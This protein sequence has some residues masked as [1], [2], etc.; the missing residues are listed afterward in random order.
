MKKI[1]AV[2]LTVLIGGTTF[3]QSG[4]APRTKALKSD[5][6]S[7]RTTTSVAPF[8]TKAPNDT[9]WTEDFSSGTGWTAT[10]QGAH[11][12]GDWQ[13]VSALTPSLVAQVPPY[14]FATAMNSA[15][16][17]NFLLVDS[18]AEGGAGTQDALITNDTPID[19]SSMGTTSLSLRFTEIYRHFY[20]EN[21]IEISND[22]GVSWTSFQVNPVSQVPVNTDSGDPEYDEVN[23]T[24]A[25]GTGTW[26]TQ[27]LI[28]FR[29]V[30]QWDWFWAVDDLAI[31]ETPANNLVMVDGHWTFGTAPVIPYSKIPSSQAADITF[32]GIVKNNGGADQPNTVVTATVT[33]PATTNYVSAGQT[34]NIGVTDTIAVGPMTAA[35]QV[36]GSY[37]V[38]WSVNSDSTDISPT[39]NFTTKWPFEMTSLVYARDNGTYEGSF[40]QAD[41]DGD[42]IFD[43]SEM[44]IDYHINNTMNVESIDV[45]FSDRTPVGQEL[46]YNIYDDAGNALYD[47]LALP[48][49]TYTIQSGDLTTGAGSEVWVTLPFTDA[50][51]N[52]W[53]TLDASTGPVFTVVVG[54]EV[55]S[56]F[57]GVSGDALAVA[58]TWTT[59][60]ITYTPSSG[61]AAVGYYLT[62]NPMIR[63]NQA[64]SA[65][66]EEV[67]NV[68]LGQN[69]P[70]PTNGTTAIPFNLMN[71]TDVEFIVTDVTGKI[72]EKRDLG[73]LASG[74][75]NI[76]FDGS[77][78]AGGIYYY[79]VIANGAIST[80]KLSIAK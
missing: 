51:A 8:N 34:V 60:G 44:S 28:R 64:P 46:Y 18:D 50:S 54:H 45:V 67:A 20:D 38:T 75:H 61:A 66:N 48:I 58:G 12:A 19:L 41:E 1:Y 71:A 74:E 11:T 27:V 62:S 22:N 47:G 30:G 76:T 2:V 52:S 56:L 5:H 42:N 10:N 23:I 14:T 21:Y 59:A 40:N 3:A 24:S 80:K 78:L 29:Y 36:P 77:S 43:A 65:V 31:V 4:L 70:N 33:G 63:M 9:I 72:I 39:D 49:P 35:E 17:G 25:I 6:F 16:G 15:S 32:S 55:D 68:A 26:G 37:V 57:I 73:T 53:I 13:I 79:S 69:V 7:G